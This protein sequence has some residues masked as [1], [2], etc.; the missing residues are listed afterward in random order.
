MKILIS[1]LGSAGKRHAQ[2]LIKLGFKNL[3]FYTKNKS[4][5]KIKIFRKIKKFSSLD[6]ALKEKPKIVFICNETNQHCKIAIKCAKRGCDLFLE[7]PLGNKI[8]EVRKLKKIIKKKKLISMVGYMLR[9]HPAIK[10]I[11]YYLEKKYIGKVYHVYSEWGEYLP[12]WHPNENYKKSYASRRNGGGTS[13]TLSHD[14]DLLRWFFGPIKK[15]AIEKIFKTSLKIKAESVSDYLIKF[16]SGMNAQ[17]HLD[18]LQKD[19]TRYLKILGENGKIIFKYYE[20][21][22]ILEKSNTKKK[23]FKFNKFDRN[24]MFI[25]EIK[26]F[27]KC[28]KKRRQTFLNVDESF[29]L[30]V[31][32]KLI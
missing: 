22:L 4:L 9:F 15:I 11:K 32:T 26:H 1:G 21:K 8:T 29:K 2:N 5:K 31:E 14:I 19:P 16:N 24:D 6:R 23:T 28:I 3:I 13:L 20:K 25:E 17:I 12:N 10:K 27:F 7:K 30:L 18:Y